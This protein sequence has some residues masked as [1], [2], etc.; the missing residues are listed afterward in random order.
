MTQRRMATCLVMLLLVILCAFGWMV[1]RTTAQ[2]S[3]T[4][5]PGSSPPISL[6]MAT[7]VI[8]PFV[9]T[10]LGKPTE[11][12]QPPESGKLT[13][14]GK[15]T[16]F[17]IE[18]WEKITAQMQVSYTTQVYDTLPEMLAAVKANQADLA[19]AA[20]SITA[21]RMEQF[22]FSYPMFAAGLQ[23]LV[24]NPGRGG[25]VPNLLRDLFS[26]VILQLVG[27]AVIMVAIA[28]HI[29]WWF[30]RGHPETMISCHYL[31]GILEAAWWAAATL[32]TQA[33]QMPKGLL[34]RIL[35][36]FWM[37]TAVVFV[38]YFTATVTTSMTVQQ[39]Q[40]DINSVDDLA[41]RT[42][43]TTTGSTAADFL[44]E[45][46]IQ[47]LAKPTID[48]A[49]AA[50]LNKQADAVV[51]DS[52]VLMHYAAQA[53]KGKVMLAGEIFR[54]ESYGILLSSNSPYRIAVNKALLQIKE[55]GG[56]Q[57][58]YQR[59]FKASGENNNDR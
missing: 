7:R 21:E 49:Y 34:S 58:L 3:P 37:F 9:M 38:A 39:L 33:D 12:S 15:L 19:I 20:I 55:N 29:I 10:E 23:I 13:E 22:D 30:E 11:S 35:A 53:G 6:R 24:R 46:Q 5:P 47:T 25:F 28:S 27:L 48:D 41:G 14:P 57:K 59:W 50:L 45:H 43:A 26:P 16:G 56:Y 42:V 40:G 18:L 44:Q 17:S 8:P 1:P 4:K 31:P 51:F 52:P 54:E 2:T 36:V 32:A